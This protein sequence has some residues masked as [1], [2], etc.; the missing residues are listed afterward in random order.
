MTIDDQHIV[1]GEQGRRR[2]LTENEFS[3]FALDP[4]ATILGE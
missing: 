1:V 2:E 4:V 3:S